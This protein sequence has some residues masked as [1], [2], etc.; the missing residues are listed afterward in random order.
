MVQGEIPRQPHGVLVGRGEQGVGL[1]GAVVRTHDSLGQE[2]VP[3]EARHKQVL[4]KQLLEEFCVC[5]C[6]AV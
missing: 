4:A 2:E 6:V 1:R 5:V 3:E